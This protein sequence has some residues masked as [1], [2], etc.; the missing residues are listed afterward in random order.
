MITI[1][2]VVSMGCAVWLFG[3]NRALKQ[4]NKKLI[5]SSTMVV[6]DYFDLKSE[7]D[8]LFDKCLDKN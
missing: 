8:I 5:K 2:A 7:Y 4:I 1:L 6:D 3:E